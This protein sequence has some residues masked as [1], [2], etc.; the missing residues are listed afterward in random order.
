MSQLPDQEVIPNDAEQ[1]LQQSHGGWTGESCLEE[2]EKVPLLF[3]I[4]RVVLLQSHG[5]PFME[6]PEEEAQL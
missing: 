3:C 2:E 5:Q 6:G 1:R 4:L